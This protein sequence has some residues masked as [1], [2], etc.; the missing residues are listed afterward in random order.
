MH[1]MTKHAWLL[2]IFYLTQV[3]TPVYSGVWV[4]SF[5]RKVVVRTCSSLRRYRWWENHNPWQMDFFFLHASSIMTVRQVSIIAPVSISTFASGMASHNMSPPQPWHVI[6]CAVSL[7]SGVLIREDS[8]DDNYS[9]F[10]C[11]F[12]LYSIHLFFCIETRTHQLLGSSFTK[13]VNGSSYDWLC[14][15]VHELLQKTQTGSY[16]YKTDCTLI[17]NPLLPSPPFLSVCNYVY[18]IIYLSLLF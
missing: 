6:L 8:P 13:P 4:D 7:Y 11:T 16:Q 9:S 15:A 17:P 1:K 10:P 18:L 12:T 14:R 2:M 5:Q 3:A